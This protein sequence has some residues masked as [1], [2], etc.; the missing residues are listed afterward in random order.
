[1]VDS[2]RFACRHCGEQLNLGATLAGRTI[3]CP[4]C[5]ESATVPSGSP[6]SPPPIPSPNS[7]V[8]Y[9]PACGLPNLENN[10]RCTNCGSELHQPVATAVLVEDPLLTLIPLKNLPAL[11]AYY[12]GVFSLIPCFGVFLG[13]AAIVLGFM[14]TAHAR[15]HPE[16]RGAIHAWAGILLGLLVL[17]GHLSVIVFLFFIKK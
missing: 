4:K 1:M 9:C 5:G 7:G 15:K 8:I 10:F 2:I 17:L 16:A 3:N 14:G 13:I 6:D 12:L 11:W